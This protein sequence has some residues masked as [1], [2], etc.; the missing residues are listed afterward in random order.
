MYIVP[1]SGPKN[2]NAVSLSPY[3]IELHWDPPSFEDQ[4]GDIVSYF[5][6]A[7]SAGDRQSFETSGET[8][9][10]SGNNFH[11]YYTY[12][13]SVHA[14]TVGV[15]PGTTVNVTTMETGKL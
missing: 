10:F 13:I 8:L 5:I 15:G 9:F 3:N 12:S 1:S 4:N 2:V 7:I 14:V 6:S 11:P